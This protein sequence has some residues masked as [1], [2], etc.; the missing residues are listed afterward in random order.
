MA[1]LSEILVVALYK[2]PEK[3][4]TKKG[5]KREAHEGLCPRG[6]PDTKSG[7]TQAPSA[8]DGEQG[9]DGEEID[10]SRT[11][12]RVA[13]DDA[14]EDQGPPAQKKQRRD[15][16]VLYDDSIDSPDESEASEETSSLV[17]A[18]QAEEWAE[19]NRR[20]KSSDYE[21]DR[22]NKRFDE[23]QTITAE[24]KT[25]RD[26]LKKAQQEAAQQKAADE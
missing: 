6:P 9:E 25:L 1:L 18:A 26:E 2:A 19:L 22:I 20:L 23:A 7:E 14:E 17:V 3:K 10:S 15:K 13:L 24:V 16:V 11:R 5:E 12:K 4:E 21:L 8:H